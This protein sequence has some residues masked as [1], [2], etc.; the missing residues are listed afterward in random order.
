[1]QEALA[2]GQKRQRTSEEI[3][4]RYLDQKFKDQTVSEEELRQYYLENKYLFGDLDLDPLKESLRD[5][6]KEQKRQKTVRRYNILTLGQRMPIPVNEDWVK[7][8]DSIIN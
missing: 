7:R 8:Q 2:Q 4:T 1:L 6:L 5:F 3:V